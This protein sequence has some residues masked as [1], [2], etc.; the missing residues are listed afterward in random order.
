MK[1]RSPVLCSLSCDGA[2]NL[3][4]SS[5][6]P[7]KH[8]SGHQA[9]TSHSSKLLREPGLHLA[10]VGQLLLGYPSIPLACTALESHGIQS[11]REPG[12]DSVELC[13]A[14]GSESSS[15]GMAQRRNRSSNPEVGTSFHL[16]HISYRTLYPVPCTTHGRWWLARPQRLLW[17][18][19]VL[20]GGQWQS[21]TAAGGRQGQG[22][23]SPRPRFR[24]C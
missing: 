1:G 11:H 2:V 22:S 24:R 16:N 4:A 3:P 5:G 23:A 18:G 6:P 13:A 17:Q 8:L 9:C 20:L 15:S 12:A 21:E 10:V 7:T 14:Q 19:M